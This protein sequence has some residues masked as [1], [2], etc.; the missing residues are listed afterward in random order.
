MFFNINVP[1]AERFEITGVR[2]NRILKYKSKDTKS[3]FKISELYALDIQTFSVAQESTV[4]FKLSPGPATR[5]PSQKP[6]LVHWFE[7]S[8]SSVELDK[9]MEENEKLGLGEEAQWN[10]EQISELGIAKSIYL[11]ALEMLKKMDG[12][13]QYNYN[14]QDVRS[15]LSVSASQLTG[16]PDQQYKFW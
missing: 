5:K 11:P 6:G 13:G 1:M 14:G 10:P 12:I 3:M 4:Y 7:A 16:E 8:I 9:I 15:G 2:S